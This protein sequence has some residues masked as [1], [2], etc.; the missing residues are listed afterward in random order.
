MMS[1]AIYKIHLYVFDLLQQL[2]CL[3]WWPIKAISRILNFT[4]LVFKR[5]QNV[6]TRCWKCGK[7]DIENTKTRSRKIGNYKWFLFS[8]SRFRLRDLRFRVSAFSNV[9]WTTPR[10]NLICEMFY[11]IKK[12]L[13]WWWLLNF[14][15]HSCIYVIHMRVPNYVLI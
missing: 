5:C 4:F 13:I 14:W 3:L 11:L 2:F 6:K 9:Y 1:S 15:R 8:F 7:H 12:K 10:K